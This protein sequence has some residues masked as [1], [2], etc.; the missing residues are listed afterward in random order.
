[1]LWVIDGQHRIEGFRHAIND[2]GQTDLNDYHMPVVI[3]SGLEIQQEA[4]QFR[5]INETAQKVRTDLARRILA[6]GGG[7]MEERRQLV[8]QRRM[9]EAVGANVAQMLNAA[10]ESPLYQR[11]QGPN[12]KKTASHMVKELSFVTSLRPIL[13]M[14][15]YSRARSYRRRALTPLLPSLDRVHRDSLRPPGTSHLSRSGA[16]EEPDSSLP[17]W[18][19][20]PGYGAALPPREPT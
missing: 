10:P 14:H 20:R 15:P 7:T 19:G 3:I 13:T 16:E 1:M 11:I 12:E 4:E 2:L 17:Q 18:A 8:E 6:M 9:W 5:V